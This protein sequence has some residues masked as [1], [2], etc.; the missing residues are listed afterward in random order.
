MFAARQHVVIT[1]NCQLP[2][3]DAVIAQKIHV[4]IAEQ[5]NSTLHAIDI[6]L[7]GQY[8]YGFKIVSHPVYVNSYCNGTHD[9][10]IAQD[11]MEA[12]GFSFDRYSIASSI[13]IIKRTEPITTISPSYVTTLPFQEPIILEAA[14]NSSVTVF[15]KFDDVPH[16][17]YWLEYNVGTISSDHTKF[18]LR[19][20]ITHITK[21]VPDHFCGGCSCFGLSYY[22]GYVCVEQIHS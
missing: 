1:D 14:Y 10:Y 21:A 13:P 5:P 20:D 6:P 7:N 22:N 19:S 15:I 17:D 18:Q 4:K 16:V 3:P 8:A 2:Q 9:I 11:S 12:V